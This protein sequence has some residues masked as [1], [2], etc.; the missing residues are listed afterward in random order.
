[1]ACLGFKA[2]PGQEDRLKYIFK[3][4]PSVP[5]SERSPKAYL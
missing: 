2:I 5:K 1:M 3:L 4:L